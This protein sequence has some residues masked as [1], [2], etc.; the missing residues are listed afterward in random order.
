[1]MKS[2]KSMK[3][4]GLLFFCLVL[5][6]EV[7][8]GKVLASTIRSD[9]T[10]CTLTSTIKLSL[11]T[12]W[13][14]NYINPDAN[15]F[16][17]LLIP[18]LNCQSDTL[19]KRDTLIYLNAVNYGLDLLNSAPHTDGHLI[20]KYLPSLHSLSSSPVRAKIKYGAKVVTVQK[21]EDSKQITSNPNSLTLV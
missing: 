15:V 9:N 5:V 8:C 16:F 14:V 17:T 1:M 7:L 2:A 21:I 19:E 6:L 18:E 13:K 20:R 12:P 11:A 4:S 10:N 3:D